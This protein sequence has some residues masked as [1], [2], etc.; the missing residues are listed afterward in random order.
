MNRPEWHTPKG[1]RRRDQLLRAAMDVIA[2]RGY[3]GAT[4]RSIARR[5]GVPPASTHY[6]FDSVDELAREAAAEHLKARAAA[7]EQLID[8]FLA[9]E[10][11]PADGIREVVRVLSEVAIEMRTAQFEI[12][13]N[14]QRQPELHDVVVDCLARF[15]AVGARMLAAAGVPDAE[16]WGKAV[17]ALGDGFALQRVAGTPPPVEAFE[18]ALLALVIAGRMSDDERAAWDSLLQTP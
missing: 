6:F 1:Q 17:L 18:E 14:A 9:E 5:A 13:L 10:R 4:Q 11:S 16:R 15:E 7:Y 8:A 3:A 12:Y 2:E